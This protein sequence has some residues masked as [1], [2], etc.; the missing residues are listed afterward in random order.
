MIVRPGGA[1]RGSG[2]TPRPGPPGTRRHWSSRLS[3][4]LASA[5]FA[6]GLGN[7][8]R[9]PFVV[10]EHGGSAFVLVYLL[11][12]FGLGVPLLTAELMLGRRGQKD[13]VGSMAALAEEA[14]ASPRWRHVGTLAMLTAAVVMSFYPVVAGWTLHYL[15]LSIGGSLAGVDA[16]RSARLL[17]DLHADPALLFFWQLVV[18]AAA[19]VILVRGLN[20]GLERAVNVLMP[21]LFVLLVAMVAH[22]ALVG[23]L[24][25]AAHF[26]LVPDFGALTPGAVLVAVGQ[27]FFSVGIAAA[28]MMTYGA[29]LDRDAPLVRS[30]FTVVASD[31]LVALLAG[32]AVFPMVFAAGLEPAEGPGLIFVTVPVA[33]A[34]LP[35]SA[36]AGAAFFLLLFA[37]ALTSCI[38]ALEAVVLWAEE[39]LGVDRRRAVLGA[40]GVSVLLGLGVV[41]S[42]NR[43]ADFHPLGFLPVFEGQTLFGLFEYAATN[44]LMPVGGLLMALFAGWVL[45]RATTRDE[46]GL[47]DGAA[48]R[49]W[50][51]VVRFAGPAAIAV[52]LVMGLG[53]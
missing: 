44:L 35:G 1:R 41:F 28:A 20:A 38:G 36:F 17:A 13:V 53:G 49:V 24:G 31:T 30:A 48:F 19:A 2:Y 27:A 43:L 8:W 7:I 9:F 6:V 16:G 29:Y 46:L 39:Q 15:V 47:G 40:T 3:F 10:G 23:D 12:A 18:M 4:L 21:A 42:F 37:A 45:P 34:S 5:G 14:G 33:F 11:A 25:A 26:L 52:I 32:F 51:L 50:L 22:G